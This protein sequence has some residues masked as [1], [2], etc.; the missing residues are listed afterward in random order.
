MQNRSAARLLSLL[1]LPLI[2]A[3][4]HAETRCGAGYYRFPS[5]SGDAIVFT[6]EGDLWRAAAAGGAAQRL[7]SHPG[8][9]Q[10]AAISPDGKSVAF[11]AQYEG[12]TEVCI[13]PLAGGPVTRLTFEGEAS[14]RPRARLDARR[15]HPLQHVALRDSAPPANS[16]PSIRSRAPAPSC[17]SLKPM[18]A[19]TT[20][21][22][23]RSSSPASPRRA[24]MSNAT[25][26]APRKTS[27]ASPPATPK[28]PRSPRPTPAPAAGRC[29]SAG[30]LYFASDRDGTMNLWSMLP[31]SSD[32][33]QH[34]RHADFGVKNPS[35]SHGRIV[36]Q[37]GA[38]LWL[39]DLATGRNAIIPIT[40]TS[41]FDQTREKWVAKPI[42]YV[43]NLAI[44]PTGDRVALTARGQVFVAPTGP[45][46]F[47]EATRQSGVRYREASFLGDG[48]S[49]LALSDESG[50][51][52]FWRLP[53]NGVGPREQLTKDATVLRLSGLPSPDG[54][55]IASAERD[56]ELWLFNTKTTEKRRIATSGQGDF[57]NPDF[58]WSPD[59]Q[60]LAFVNSDANEYGVIWLYSL[61]T[62]KAV[63]VTSPRTD[64]NSPAWSPDGKWLYFLSARALQTVVGAPWG[65]RQPEPFL[66]RSV[67]LYQL[68]LANDTKRS[69][70]QPDDELTPTRKKPAPSEKK[71]DEPDAKSPSETP[72]SETE[73]PKS[74]TQTTVV[75][76]DGLA[77]RLWE[78]PV[79]AG[80][81]SRLSV[82]DKNLFF[83]DR[84]RGA[85]P[86]PEPAGAQTHRRR[87]RKQR[88][89]ARHRRRGHRHL[90]TLRRRQKTPPPPHQR[91]LRHRRR[92]Q[93]RRPR[94]RQ[95]QGQ[96][97]SAQV[98]L[99][100]RESS[101]QM[102][103]D[104]WRLH[105]DY[106]YDAAMH[107]VDWK[108]NLAKHLPLV[109]RV[110][111][112]AELNDVL[113]YMMSETSALH[114][115]LQPGDVRTG[116]EDEIAPPA[117]LGARLTRDDAAGGLR[118][119]HIYEGDPDYP[120]KLSPLARPGQHIAVG[121]IIESINGT[122]VLAARDPDALLRNQAGRQ[123][124][125]RL[126]PAAGGD[127]FN[128]IVSPI[129]SADAASLRYTDWEQTRRRRVD[130]AGANRIG[131]V[132]LRA[133]GAPDYAQWMRDFYPV[134]NRAGLVLDLRNNRGGNIDSWILPA[135]C[136][137]RGCGGLRVSGMSQPICSP[138]SAVISSSSS[139]NPPPPTARLS[140][141][142]CAASASARSSAPAP[143]AAASGSAASTPW[144]TKASSAPPKTVPSSPAK[145]GL[146]RAPASRPIWSWTTTPR[147][148]SAA[149]T[150]NSKPPSRS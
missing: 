72:S 125:L 128:A 30:R 42:D 31:D 140:P 83:L 113:T 101:R 136:A 47:V 41:D 3:S 6:A 107:G 66:D 149:R 27:G 24:A 1:A 94:A 4:A 123:V 130:E 46:R 32:L 10:L 68:A 75:H 70:F 12:Q 111:D 9:E 26:V 36:Y 84:A 19:P 50:E 89:R 108:S 63:A 87:N 5:L 85:A 91:P 138:P 126:K 77:A 142:A 95:G 23:K 98:L 115:A 121:D 33:R 143:G 69:P 146:S 114:T 40:L 20:T 14:W 67:K 38:D 49:L 35:L 16:S 18:R 131:Y 45:G 53:A 103:T 78:V 11:S 86:G 17:P 134:I 122:A 61:A 82:A 117:S 90:R 39:L 100:P 56:Q 106:F 79:P 43:T 124:L 51:V 133:M 21:R 144:W 25:R 99:P 88:H 58:A 8:T 109:D 71:T 44:S 54:T 139:T 34:T 96:P 119:L 120:D 59:G 81:Y 145:A 129:T 48:K 62:D 64:S 110:N 57:D 37:N 147:A 150:S 76:L 118:I 29:W 105:R 65:L 137:N 22:A 80:N 2:I 73:N 148:P 116:P 112:R 93:A 74:K 127:A 132:H 60:W 102:F 55:W 104:A 92:R 97:L 52:E 7:T 13:M 28:P 141:T 15:P 135:S